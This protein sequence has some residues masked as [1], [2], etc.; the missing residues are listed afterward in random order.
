MES[1]FTNNFKRE[2]EPYWRFNQVRS[3]RNWKLYSF[4]EAAYQTEDLVNIEIATIGN[5]KK[6][7]IMS[8]VVDLNLSFCLRRNRIPEHFIRFLK[9][10]E[11]K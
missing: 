5:Y 4:G 3:V 8:N 1:S 9:A 6:F 7:E 2:G 10:N 11:G